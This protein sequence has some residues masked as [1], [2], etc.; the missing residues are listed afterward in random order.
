MLWPWWFSSVFWNSVYH[1]LP[2]KFVTLMYKGTVFVHVQPRNTW[3]KEMFLANIE[4]KYPHHPSGTTIGANLWGRTPAQLHK[5]TCTQLAS[6]EVALARLKLNIYQ[7]TYI[8][9]QNKKCGFHV[10]HDIIRF[11]LQFRKTLSKSI[12][13][14][15]TRPFC[16]IQEI[17][18]VD[19]APLRGPKTDPIR[20]KNP[21]FNGSTTLGAW[22]RGVFF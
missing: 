1:F 9:F 19:C 10:T 4:F 18:T 22:N 13:Q 14:P 7:Y 21:E 3:T 17:L 11:H 5:Q 15:E 2:N 16:S 8:E 12:K 6:P 20:R